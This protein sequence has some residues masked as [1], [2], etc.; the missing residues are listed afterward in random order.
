MILQ[1]APNMGPPFPKLVAKNLVFGRSF[2]VEPYFS[3][4]ATGWSAGATRYEWVFSR[5]GV[6]R[7]D[8]LR[9]KQSMGQ[10][11]L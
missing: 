1:S 9:S 8:R 7:M 3:G 10:G 4:T 2:P 6:V 11:L 5:R